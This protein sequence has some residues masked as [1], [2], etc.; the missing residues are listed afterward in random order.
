MGGRLITPPF[1]TSTVISFTLRPLY[2]LSP[3][4]GK[5]ELAPF[6]SAGGLGEKEKFFTCAAIETRLLFCPPP[7][8]IAILI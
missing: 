4:A 3:P 1:L 5:Y 2:T 8:L 6:A 7:S